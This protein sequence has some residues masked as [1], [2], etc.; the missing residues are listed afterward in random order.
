MGG[1]SLSVPS[2]S[3]RLVWLWFPVFAAERRDRLE[4]AQVARLTAYRHACRV[5]DIRQAR[6]HH[7][8]S[9]QGYV[10]PSGQMNGSVWCASCFGVL[11]AI[12]FRL[13]GQSGNSVTIPHSCTPEM[14]RCECVQDQ[15]QLQLLEFTHVARHQRAY[16]HWGVACRCC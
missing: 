9:H 3:L 15:E 11:V 14:V 16:E 7:Q 1:R 5:Y 10:T 8:G 6:V 4:H 2:R 13:Q 12:Y